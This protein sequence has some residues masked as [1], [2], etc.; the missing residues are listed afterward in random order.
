MW[1][2][3]FTYQ[4]FAGVILTVT[5]LKHDD[6]TFA[7]IVRDPVA[8]VHWAVM[9][10]LVAALGFAYSRMRRKVERHRKLFEARIEELASRRGR[11]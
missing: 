9:I 7:S 6:G 8:R 2:S 1:W 5:G 3:A 4:T 10:T 11:A